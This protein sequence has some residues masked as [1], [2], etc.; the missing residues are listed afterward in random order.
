MVDMVDMVEFISA[1]NANIGNV[2]TATR[3]GRI[4]GIVYV[5]FLHTATPWGVAVCFGVSRVP[6][7]PSVAPGTQWVP[8][9]F[10]HDVP[11][12]EWPRR[13]SWQHCS[14]YTR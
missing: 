7:V 4:G 3:I 14:R 13:P 2:E 12:D 5:L 6:T 10:T 11:R 8:G 9:A 1:P